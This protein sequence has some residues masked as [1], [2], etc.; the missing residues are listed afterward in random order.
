MRLATGLRKPK[1]PCSRDGYRGDGRGGRQG[2]DASFDPATR[3]SAGAPARS[4]STRGRPRTSSLQKPANLT[5]SRRPPSACPRRPRS[6]SCAT[7]G[8][9][10][11]G[12]EGADQWRVG[13]RRHVR[14]ADRQGVRCRGDRREQHEE[15]RHG[16]LHRRRPCHRLH[17]E[18]FTKGGPRYDLILDNVGN[19]SMARDPARPDAPAGRCS[20][21]AE[22][23]PAASWAHLIRAHVVSMFVRQQARPSVKSQNPADLVALRPSSKRAR[24]CR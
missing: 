1:N 12:P 23:M 4:P 24:S 17:A 3:S 2:R 7:T 5:S 13:R 19:H 18:D 11:P 21:T 22:G 20:P 9:V 8:K 14:R 15:R 10:Q 16:P 6:S